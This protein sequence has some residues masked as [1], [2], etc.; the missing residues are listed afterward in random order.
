MQPRK[1]GVV[2]VIVRENKLLVIR[3][4]QFVRA[5]GKYCFPG[6]AMEPGES[7]TE[8][9]LREIREELGLNVEPLQFLHRSI[10][11]WHVDLRWWQASTSTWELLRPEPLEVESVHWLTVS[12][13]LELPD[14]LESNRTFIAAWREGT[15]EIEGLSRD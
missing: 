11:P 10:T 5:A 2:A 9:L 13:M 3:R 1:I 15:F 6:G 12:E 7:E 8:T 14:L 4:S